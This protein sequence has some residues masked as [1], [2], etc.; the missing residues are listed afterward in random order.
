MA[1]AYDLIVIGSGTA[2]MVAG[3]RLA[4]AGRRV[5][6]MD[7]RPFGGTCGAKCWVHNLHFC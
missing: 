7:H 3:N 1:K 2:A 5:A 6:V 4:S